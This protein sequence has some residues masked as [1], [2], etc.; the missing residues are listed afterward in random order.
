MRTAAYTVSRTDPGRPLNGD[1]KVVV[2]QGRVVYVAKLRTGDWQLVEEWGR[3]VASEAAV[4]G[5]KGCA[6][7]NGN[8]C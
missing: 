5:R 2:W 1:T 6:L 3:R 7:L 8:H 4:A